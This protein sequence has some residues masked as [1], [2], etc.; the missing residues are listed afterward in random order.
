VGREDLVA[1]PLYRTNKDRT[2]NW[3]SLERELE[4][5]FAARTVD[6]WLGLLEAAGI[7]C[8]PINTIDKVI[9]DPQVQAREMVVEV[10]HPVAGRLK[11]AGCPIKMSATPAG[12]I[13]KPAPLLGQHS[14]EVL[15]RYLGMTDEEI[16]LLK[17]QGVI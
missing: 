7:P 10:E 12:K 15:S 5:I 4:K 17:K 9:S 16:E 1:N 3:D 14:R 13:R 2:D 6:E 11:M 8:G